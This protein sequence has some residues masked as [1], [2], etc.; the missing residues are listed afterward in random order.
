M[1]L[2]TTWNHSGCV[3]VA[4]GIVPPPL[5]SRDLGSSQYLSR[6]NLALNKS[7]KLS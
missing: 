7:N 2:I 5:T 4:L 6:D 3:S 1:D